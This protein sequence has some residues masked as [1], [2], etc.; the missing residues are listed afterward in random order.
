MTFYAVVLF[1]F[2]SKLSG[3]R[4]ETQAGATVTMAFL[5]SAFL[6]KSALLRPGVYV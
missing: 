4:V 1:V 3:L 2:R 6:G 5:F